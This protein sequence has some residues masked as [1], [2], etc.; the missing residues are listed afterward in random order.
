MEEHGDVNVRVVDL[1]RLKPINRDIIIKSAQQGPIVTAE[2]NNI[3]AC[4]HGAVCEVTAQE[5]PCTVVP[6]GMRDH[7]AKSGSYEK[8][9][10]MYNLDYKAIG[11]ACYQALK[12]EKRF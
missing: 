4:L 12:R 5:L 2:A 1:F 9:T 10:V 6:I 11:N 7:F 3:H 8:L